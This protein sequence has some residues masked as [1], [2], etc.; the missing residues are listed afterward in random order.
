M[1]IK[2]KIATL[3]YKGVD[4]YDPYHPHLSNMWNY[5]DNIQ[6]FRNEYSQTL[7]KLGG[8]DHVHKVFH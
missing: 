2:L 8:Y 4:L 5:V 6:P 7:E 1:Q 3:V